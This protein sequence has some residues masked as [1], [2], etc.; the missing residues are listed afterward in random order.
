MDS[1]ALAA[2]RGAE[3]RPGAPGRRSEGAAEA[4]SGDL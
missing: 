4:R 3:G 1:A 2:L